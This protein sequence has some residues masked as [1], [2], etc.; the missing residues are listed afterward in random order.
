MASRCCHDH[1]GKDELKLPGR[2]GGMTS[3][4]GKRMLAGGNEEA[5]LSS[6]EHHREAVVPR[7]E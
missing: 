4:T 1:V 6:R 3:A 7:V 5:L 2:Q